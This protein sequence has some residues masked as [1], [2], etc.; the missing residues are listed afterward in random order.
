MQVEGTIITIFWRNPTN[1]RLKKVEKEG[2]KIER[3]G[4]GVFLKMV[5]FSLEL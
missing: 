1:N 4:N 2:L 3:T 5:H